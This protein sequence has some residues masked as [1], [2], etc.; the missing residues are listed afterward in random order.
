MSKPIPLQYGKYYHIFNRGN[1][2]DNIFL[3]ERNYHHFLKLY[4]KYIVPTADTFAY[5][6]LRNHFHLLVRTKT[7][8]EQ[9]KFWQAQKVTDS[10]AKTQPAWQLIH[11]SQAFGICFNA[12]AKAINAGYNHTGSL[13][14]HPFGRIQVNSPEYM[15]QLVIYIHQNAQKHGFVEDFR[16]WPFSSYPAFRSAKFTHLFKDKVL[17]WFGDLDTFDLAH[18]HEIMEHQIATFAPGDFNK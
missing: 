8:P 13:F 1:N 5:C 10:L 9:E 16:T 18:R 4:T 7:A 3:E 11:P 2:G 17:S 6:L 15:A 12:Y 14:E